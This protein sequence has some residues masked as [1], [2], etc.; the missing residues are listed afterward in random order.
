MTNICVDTYW[1]NFQGL[2]VES[3][4]LQVEENVVDQFDDAE[5]EE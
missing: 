1:G 2:S 5:E 3:P 4:D